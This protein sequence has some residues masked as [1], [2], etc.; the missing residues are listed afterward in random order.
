M[1]NPVVDDAELKMAARIEALK[2]DLTKIRTG[3]ASLS[4]LDSIKVDAYGS[5]M[6]LNQVAALTI[7]EPRLILYFSTFLLRLLGKNGLTA[8]ER[9]MG[10][11]LVA[12]SIQLFLDGVSMYSSHP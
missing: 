7:P 9:L 1:G 10:M 3:R 5:K 4:L 2:R 8:V 11:I 6:P 12:I